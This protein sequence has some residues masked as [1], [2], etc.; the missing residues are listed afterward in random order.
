VE[1]HDVLSVRTGRLLLDER[2]GAVGR[3]RTPEE[4]A[5]FK[6]Q[7]TEMRLAGIGAKRIAKELQIS[8][9]LLA[10][11]LRDV[12]PPSQLKRMRAKDDHRAAAIRLRREGRTYKEIQKELG[13]SKGSLSLWLRDVPF[14][15]GHEREELARRSELPGPE[16]S[17]TDDAGIARLLRLQGWFV[18]EVADELGVTVATAGAWCAG[19]PAPVRATHGSDPAAVAAARVAYWDRERER[20]ALARTAQI[21][22]AM[23]RVD[24]IDDRTLDLLVAVAYWCEGAKSKPWRK[25]DRVIFINSDPDLVRLLMEWLRRRGI[26]SDRMRLALSIHES[27][28]VD[29]ATAFWAEAIGVPAAEFR[30]PTLKR[31]NPKTVRK[32]TG[33]RYVGCLTLAV[34]ESRDVY[35]EIEGLW[36]GIVRAVLAPLPVAAD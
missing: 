17:P 19:L 3:H 29:A 23:A 30:P 26:E 15:T 4:K 21:E 8:G 28:D 34:R 22:L 11:L 16:E 33:Q 12:P 25:L 7:A 13:V 27:A 31:H 1:S 6:A 18:R 14:P 5:A 2:R 9:E 24:H 36:R 20:R 32:N 10:E 35:R